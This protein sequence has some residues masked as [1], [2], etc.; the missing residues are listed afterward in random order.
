MIQ[1]NDQ[2]DIQK[3]ASQYLRRLRQ[4]SHRHTKISEKDFFLV[5]ILSTAVV[6]LLGSVIIEV[7]VDWKTTDL[8]LV[9]FLFIIQVTLSF[10]SIRHSHK[11]SRIGEHLGSI[12]DL[13]DFL[14]NIGEQ[15]SG[16]SLSL[17]NTKKLL[18]TNVEQVGAL[19][20][21]L[22][23][24]R[25]LLSN[26]NLP[27]DQNEIIG[28]ILSPLIQDRR[29]VLSFH[30]PDDLYNI[31]VYTK[32]K[33]SGRL[34]KLFRA[35]DDRIDTKNRDWAE[36]VGH[37]GICFSLS[38][39]IISPDTKKSDEFLSDEKEHDL[40][41]Y[42]SIAAFPIHGVNEKG[43]PTNDDPIGVLVFTSS[44]ANHFSP[45]RY[46]IFGD[47]YAH[48]LAIYFASIGNRTIQN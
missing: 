13:S 48:I 28:R 15:V 23:I 41:F 37:V 16:L 12:E 39:T 34:E 33:D 40:E 1:P 19:S 14:E 35:H 24:L 36:G 31:A 29:D 30:D 32:T 7:I 46:E 45:D 10:L 17:E 3:K 5:I 27:D 26:P 21:S 2:N 42:R 6:P 20:S 4:A 25:A 43:I 47:A 38:K 9:S 18:T 11:T 22:V 8:I 44:K